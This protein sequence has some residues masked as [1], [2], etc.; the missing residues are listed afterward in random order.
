MNRFRGYTCYIRANFR[1][2]HVNATKLTADLSQGRI[3]R[4]FQK[5]LPNNSRYPTFKG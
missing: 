4:I 3:L 2:D 5:I 1:P